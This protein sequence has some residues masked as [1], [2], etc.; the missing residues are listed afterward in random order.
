MIA[1]GNSMKTRHKQNKQIR[2]VFYARWAY[3][4]HKKNVGPRQAKY[5]FPAELLTY[6]REIFPGN[7]TGELRDATY[8]VLLQ[9]FCA[10]CLN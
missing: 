8:N 7:I 3:S 9:Q 2:Y 5:T 4:L 10:N 1:D 6:V